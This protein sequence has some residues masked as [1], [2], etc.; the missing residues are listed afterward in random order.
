MWVT[1]RK[2]F[3]Y[4]S[5]TVL[6][7]RMPSIKWDDEK[8]KNLHTDETKL[9]VSSTDASSSDPFMKRCTMTGVDSD[10]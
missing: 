9:L 3:I 1:M 8:I 4:K 7:G 5:L 6:V 10:L 2:V